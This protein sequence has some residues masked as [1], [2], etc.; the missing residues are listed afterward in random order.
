MGTEDMDI[1]AKK[2]AMHLLERMDR[3]ESQLRRK[4]TES[5]Y[6]AESVEQAIAYVKSY[7]YIDDKRYAESYIR[8]HQQQKSRLQLQM[9]LIRR[10]ISAEVIEAAMEEAYEGSEEELIR[11]LLVKKCYDAERMDRKEKY[12]IYQY[13]MRK[14]F[15]GSAVRRCMD[16]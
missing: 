1:R 3:T 8:Y 6:P 5:G 15:S 16:L 2:R 13:L 14:G 4:L 12:K 9:N 7:H 11:K 10:G